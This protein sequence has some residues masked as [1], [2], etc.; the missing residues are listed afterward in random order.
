MIYSGTK[1]IRALN[2]PDV[3]ISFDI[4]KINVA[5]L[6]M[7]QLIKECIIKESFYRKFSLDSSPY[8]KS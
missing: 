2:L 6:F 8:D 1:Q 4:Q 7:D 3:T 5:E